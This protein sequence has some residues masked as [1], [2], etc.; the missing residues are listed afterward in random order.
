VGPEVQPS[1]RSFIAMP[2]DVHARDDG[3]K[4]RAIRQPRAGRASLARVSLSNSGAFLGVTD[5]EFVAAS[6]R[7]SGTAARMRTATS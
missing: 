1:E 5:V 2:A 6:R 7:G 4:N 3:R